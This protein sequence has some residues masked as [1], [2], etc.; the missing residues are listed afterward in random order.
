M[1]ASVLV[2]ALYATSK[3]LLS[4]LSRA[5]AERV[6]VFDENVT[7]G[8]KGFLGYLKALAGSNVVKVIPANGSA[9]GSQANGKG[10]KVVCG[11]HQS[12]IPDGAWLKDKTPFT[13]CQVQVSP[14]L[15]C[16]A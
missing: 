16:N 15:R 10:L 2:Q 1:K 4:A 3:G 9:S 5:L 11:N 6:T 12:Y 7:I 14:K 13:F 8:R